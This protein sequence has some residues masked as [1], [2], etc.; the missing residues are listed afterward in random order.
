MSR[1][2]GAILVASAT[3]LAAVA[4]LMTAP[5]ARASG[6][7][8]WLIAD[9]QLAL[10]H[11]PY[12]QEVAASALV[13]DNVPPLTTNAEQY[14][15][16]FKCPAATFSY[17]TKCLSLATNP[18][19]AGTHALYDLEG[20][21]LT[22]TWE[23]Q[24]P[25]QAM[26]R[27]ATMI[28]AAGAVPVIA[29][30]SPSV[31]TLVQCAAQAAGPDGM[32]HLQVQPHEATLSAYMSRIENATTWAR[33]ISPGIAVSFGLSTNPKYNASVAKMFTAWHAATTY[34]G[35]SAPCWLNII[36]RT[37]TS[38]KKATAFLKPVYP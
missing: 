21:K 7:P 34:L 36:P 30:Q 12:R 27:A 1:I 38:A 35:P 2:T 9:S 32:V 8:S 14:T 16:I 28:R 18:P 25:C 22:S 31:Q 3:V 15:T 6:G 33:A 17:N 23:Q 20:W 13:L 19:P 26:S 37:A 10:L 4:M 5:T 29:P 11:A 24:H